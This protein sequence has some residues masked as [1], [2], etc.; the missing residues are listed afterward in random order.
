MKLPTRFVLLVLIVAGALLDVI[1]IVVVWWLEKLFFVEAGFLLLG[2]LLA[3]FT[4][5]AIDIYEQEMRAKNL[6]RVLHTEL[7]DL[8]ARCCFDS[9][10]PLHLF[11][12]PNPSPRTFN[13]IDLKKFAPHKPAIFPA[14]AGELAI[15]NGDAPQRLI[16]FHNSLTAMRRD[17]EDIADASTALQN[18]E[19]SAGQ[20]SMIALRLRL[21]LQPAL[22]ALKELGA[23]VEDA[24]EIEQDAIKTID[25]TRKE[26]APSGTLRARIELML[27]TPLRHR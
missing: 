17:I 6:A 27:K 14:V 9:E 7:A 1:F 8:A 12:G 10:A 3:I 26:P 25:A 21:T 23:M 5:F 13:V 4:S 11:W 15:L 20:V 24:D 2:A 19:V 22:N 18:I 16:Q